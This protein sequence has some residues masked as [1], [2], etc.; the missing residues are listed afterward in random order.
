M[1]YTVDLNYLI[2]LERIVRLLPK[3]MQAQWAALVDQLAEHD[4]ESTFAELTKFIASCARVASSRFGRLANCC[5]ISTLERLKEQEE[6][7]EEQ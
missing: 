2:T 3:C 6:E 4:R 1:K 7:E 5:N